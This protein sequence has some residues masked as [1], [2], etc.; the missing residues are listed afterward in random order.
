MLQHAER[1]M[2]ESTPPLARVGRIRSLTEA[3]RKRGLAFHPFRAARVR[4]DGAMFLSAPPCLRERT[5]HRTHHD[6]G[7]QTHECPSDGV[8]TKSRRSLRND[9]CQPSTP[10]RTVP[11]THVCGHSWPAAS[12]DRRS[13]DEVQGTD[14]VSRRLRRVAFRGL[15]PRAPLVGDSDGL[16]RA[17]RTSG[18]PA[19]FSMRNG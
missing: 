11:Q 2:W 15:R 19:C 9:W 3:Q 6:N 17:T 12:A 4:T 5:P 1:I 7:G 14:D 18:V 8:W 10:T 16:N 13:L